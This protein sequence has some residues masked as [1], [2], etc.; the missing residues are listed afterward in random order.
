MFERGENFVAGPHSHDGTFGNDGQLVGARENR[1]AMG[2]DHDRGAMQ[3]RS[4]DRAAQ[5]VFAV[6]IERRVR[7][8]E[9]EDARLSIERP[10]E[11]D[12]LRLPGRKLVPVAFDAGVVTI[13]QMQDQL[14]HA[15]PIRAASITSASTSGC[16]I[17][18]RRQSAR[19]FH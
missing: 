6:A 2:D 19:Y 1:R 9:Y 16:G 5:R 7:L 15:P 17:R 13:G 11:C 14:M 4:G 12:A 3:L 18:A 8:I 10:S